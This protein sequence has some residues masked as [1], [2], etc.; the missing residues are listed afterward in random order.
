MNWN[1]QDAPAVAMLPALR[2][3]FT[4]L[5]PP[6]AADKYFQIRIA[7][8]AARAELRAI[9]DK[10]AEAREDKQEAMAAIR[11]IKAE[12]TRA[13]GQA[14]DAEHPSLPRLTAQVSA[15]D[16]TLARLEGPH[17]KASEKARN[18]GQLGQALEQ[19]PRENSRG[20]MLKA[21]SGPVPTL[22]K[23][24][25][26]RDGVLRLRREIEVLREKKRA[27]A[28]APLPSSVVKEK[29]ARIV[30]ELATRGVPNVFD[31][32]ENNTGKIDWPV[33]PPQVMHDGLTREHHVA[34]LF[35]RVPD[36]VAT[37]AWL[38]PEQMLAKLEAE[39]MLRS[40][41]KNALSDAEREK[42]QQEIAAAILLL[43][44]AEEAAIEISESDGAE[45]LRRPDC[46]PRAVL[47]LA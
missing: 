30:D 20:K 14:A 13:L 34:F 28:V 9:S 21:F 33:C 47:G 27:V 3:D 46:D 2:G 41:D 38:F 42:Q 23:G 25:A 4:S 40:D 10:R 16:Q 35:L 1:M 36:T 24:E 17:G 39:I 44:R 43:E 12:F 18:L 29:A 6:A 5:F 32:L 8:D 11:N 31:I 7:A 26:P 15:A 19:W 37:L 45:I 22:R